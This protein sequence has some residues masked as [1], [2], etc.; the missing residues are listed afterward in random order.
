MWS[1]AALTRST[2]RSAC[3]AAASCADAATT[4]ARR[5]VLLVALRARRPALRLRSTA[6]VRAL[7]APSIPLRTIGST[8]A[9]T[10]SPVSAF[11]WRRLRR[12]DRSRR[13]PARAASPLAR[14][15][16][17]SARVLRVSA[18]K[19]AA[20]S[21][22]SDDSASCCD[23]SA[24]RSRSFLLRNEIIPNV[25]IDNV[26]RIKPMLVSSTRRVRR[27]SREHGVGHGST[28]S[29]NAFACCV[30]R[31]WSN[32]PG[33]LPTQAAESDTIRFLPRVS[34][35]R[36]SPSRSICSNTNGVRGAI[37][38]QYRAGCGAVRRGRA[39]RGT[40]PTPTILPTC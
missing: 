16:R 28:W 9:S 38:R 33:T 23:R 35:Y 2:T 34:A 31:V 5:S 13:R 19:R 25:P 1:T 32:A 11:R 6:S 12:L 4:F 39:R 36:T 40:A 17:F 29:A 21:S 7:R 15:S 10:S 30:T 18:A 24:R 26:F 20:C 22:S 37:P 14:F 8:L 3:G 27:R